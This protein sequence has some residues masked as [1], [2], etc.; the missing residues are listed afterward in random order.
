MIVLACGGREY[1]DATTVNSVLDWVKSDVITMP[2]MLL[3]GGA[4]GA[5]TLSRN[6]ARAKGIPEV[7]CPANWDNYGSR[8]G[9]TRNT[10]MIEF[11][12][13]A[14]FIAFP[15]RHGTAD[16][17]RKCRGRKVPGLILHHSGFHEFIKY[18]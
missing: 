5:D 6:W 1:D 7:C 13:V 10:W 18:A 17:V 4:R 12:P 16:M 9:S 3:H 11:L 8:A 2:F 14:Y 15:G